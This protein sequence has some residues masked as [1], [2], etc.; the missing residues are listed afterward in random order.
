[1]LNL[2]SCAPLGTGKTNVP[3][4]RTGFG[5]KNSWSTVVTATWSVMRVWTRTEVSSSGAKGC[6]WGS[7]GRGGTG[8]CGGG[9]MGGRTGGRQPSCS[10]TMIRPMAGELTAAPIRARTTAQNKNRFFISG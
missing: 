1:M 5:L 10:G 3:S 6:G 7:Q 4:S 2:S 8:G 9:Q